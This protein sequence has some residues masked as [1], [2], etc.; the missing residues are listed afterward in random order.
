MDASSRSRICSKVAA[1]I[2]PR[3]Y[4]RRNISI[5]DGV[6]VLVFCLFFNQY[7]TPQIRTAINAIQRSE[8]SV[9]MSIPRPAPAIS[10][11]HKTFPLSC[12]C[13]ASPQATIRDRQGLISLHR[14]ASSSFI[15]LSVSH[16]R[17][18]VSSQNRCLSSHFP[19]ICGWVKLNA[20]MTHQSPK[21]IYRRVSVIY[22]R[23]NVRNWRS[24]VIPL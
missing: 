9:I 21:A 23:Q 2:S 4:R 3:A 13:G 20:K 5:A 19:H 12:D 16:L 17:L 6:V 15:S 7:T 22:C 24:T 11:H 1:S 8:L 18:T 10:P 14:L